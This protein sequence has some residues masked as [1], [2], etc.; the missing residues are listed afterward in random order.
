MRRAALQRDRYRLSADSGRQLLEDALL[1][2]Y[3]RSGEQPDHLSDL[4]L[5]ELAPDVL[6][7]SG[8]LLVLWVRTPPRR[9]RERRMHGMSTQGKSLHPAMP[10]P[11]LAPAHPVKTERVVVVLPAHTDPADVPLLGQRP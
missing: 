3:A 8:R 10:D 2:R 11:P 4:P 5:R 6:D 1:V 7:A 9:P